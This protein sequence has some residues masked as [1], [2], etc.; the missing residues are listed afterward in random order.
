MRQRP[1]AEELLRL[2]EAMLADL[3]L[4][5]DP[6]ARSYE[7]RLAA[8]AS[9]IAEYDSVYGEADAAEEL[10]CFAALYGPATVEEAGA[11]EDA[12]IAAF[13]RRLAAEIRSGDWDAAPGSLRALLTAQVR[14]R[15]ARSNPKY[16][17]A[18]MGE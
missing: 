11:G 18:R 2:A 7:Q 17:K 14:A 15:L 9:A 5:A 10:S 13:N 8:K 12:R 4:P 3:P 16:L 1:D 6:K